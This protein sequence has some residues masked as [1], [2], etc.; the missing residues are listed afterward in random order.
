MEEVMNHL[1]N[2]I[3]YTINYFRQIRKRYGK[4]HERMTELRSF[5]TWLR[6]P[7][8]LPANAKLYVDR[9]EG[10]VGTSLK[11]DEFVCDCSDIDD[12]IV[13]LKD[14]KYIVTKV[15]DKQFVGKNIVHVAVFARND[16]RTIYN[17]AYQDGR[18]GNI[19]AKRCAI[20]GITRDKEYDLTRGAEGSKILYLSVNPNGEAEVIKVYHKPKARLKKLVF[21]FDF[22]EMA[23]KGRGSQGN[24]LTRN[25]VHKIT[26]KEKGV[27]TLG[28]RKIWFD[29]SVCRLNA[30][31]RGNFLGE[32]VSDDK[33]LVITKDGRFRMS[34]F[35]LSNHFDG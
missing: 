35:D 1:N 24:I 19:M 22:G 29:D 8:L 16:T 31:S 7:R 5:D 34:N 14:G 11:K 9:A 12:I 30:D 6:Q 21:E 23:I 26:L 15:T 27:S 33:I 4:G 17:I 13:I 3:P 20:S 10:F 32:F 25:A 28:G 18:A 2:I